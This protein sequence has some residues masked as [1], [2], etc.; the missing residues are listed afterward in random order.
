MAYGCS[1]YVA[2]ELR[3][4][5]NSGSWWWRLLMPAAGG[6]ALA[7]LRTRAIWSAIASW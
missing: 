7:N 6:T 2:G 5:A 3:G 1:G 4:L